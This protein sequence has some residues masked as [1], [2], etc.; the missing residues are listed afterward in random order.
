MWKLNNSLLN[1]N[2]I[3]EE[4][5]KEIKNFLKFNE[6]VDTSFPNLWDTMKIVLRGKF[7]ALSTLLKKLERS[8]T[9]TL[10]AHQRALELK[11]ANIAK[12]SRRQEIVKLR[13]KINQIETK[14]TIQ[15]FN[16]TKSWFFDGINKIDKPLAKLT[17]GPRCKLIKFEMKGRHN[18]K[19]GGNSR[20]HQI[21][22]EK[23]ILNKPG[24]S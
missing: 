13:A 7:I 19:N 14:R 8:Y 4:I 24:K 15:G 10:T 17:K 2:L 16:K 3:R 20:H 18:N 22:L 21:L 23:P 12:R 6:N 5:K 9:S 1:D 11:E